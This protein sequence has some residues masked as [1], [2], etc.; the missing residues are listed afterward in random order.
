MLY[1]R[2]VSTGV[3]SSKNY[4]V[5]HKLFRRGA[6][7]AAFFVAQEVQLQVVKTRSNF[8]LP[9]QLAR[10]PVST[11]TTTARGIAPFLPAR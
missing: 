3:E 2:P 10:I 4:L 1:Q 9:G 6:L 5:L 8:V 11:L 7:A